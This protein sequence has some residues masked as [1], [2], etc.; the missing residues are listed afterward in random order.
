MYE[1]L[2]YN[3][4]AFSYPIFSH[5]I[6]PIPHPVAL[7]NAHVSVI[8][9]IK[10]MFLSYI[11]TTITDVNYCNCSVRLCSSYRFIIQ[12]ERP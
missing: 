9:H 1:L 8:D 11:R 5:F 12:I 10:L 7:R 2:V 3:N 4:Q 6:P